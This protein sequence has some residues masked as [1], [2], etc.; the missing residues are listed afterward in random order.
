MIDFIKAKKLVLVNKLKKD[1]FDFSAPLVPFLFYSQ[2]TLFS[3]QK[4]NF[5][6]AS[7][8]QPVFSNRNLNAVHL[9][10]S[11]LIIPH[12]KL[13]NSK[14]I[15][16]NYFTTILSSTEK[17]L[18]IIKLFY[19]FRIIFFIISMYSELEKNIVSFPTY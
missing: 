5:I 3:T 11:R 14:K 12:Q 6:L 2:V 10:L 15:P 8:T 18:E 9:Y 19:L 16:Y 7:G 1:L 4:G 13:S 17:I